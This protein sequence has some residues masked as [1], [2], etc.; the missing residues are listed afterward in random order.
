[1][2]DGLS[3][4][5]NP[6]RK[7]VCT[8]TLPMVAN[9]VSRFLRGQKWVANH[10][11]IAEERYGESFLGRIPTTERHSCQHVLNSGRTVTKVR[12]GAETDTSST[13]ARGKLTMR[14][15]DFAAERRCYVLSDQLELGSFA[16][17]PA[18]PQRLSS[19]RRTCLPGAS[20]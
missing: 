8:S 15:S 20:R 3:P 5:A 13:T 4:G 9:I 18:F 12:R 6:F 19:V 7:D 16:K 1:M 14:L 11:R 17:F 2:D 10:E